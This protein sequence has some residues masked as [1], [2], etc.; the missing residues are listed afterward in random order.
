MGKIE[1]TLH[2]P[3]WHDTFGEG[4]VYPTQIRLTFAHGETVALD[5][6]LIGAP[7]A[8]QVRAGE[9]TQIQIELE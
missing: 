1:V 3:G 2:N 8:E 7:Y 5:G 6:G 4:A 9:I